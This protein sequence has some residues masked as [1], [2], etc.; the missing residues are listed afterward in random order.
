MTVRVL[1]LALA[2]VALTGELS[3]ISL[4]EGVVVGL[5]VAAVSRSADRRASWLL[6]RWPRALDLLGFFLWELVLSNLRVAAVVV[7]GERALDPAFVEVPLD[8]EDDGAIALFANLVTL[9][10]GTLSVDV[11]PHAGV[12]HVHTLSGSDP[13]AVCRELKQGF[14]R[15]IQELYR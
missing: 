8:L 12:L 13:D 1:L 2:W 5:L 9:T 4:A 6:R 15:R 14:E 3:V 7:R 10:P 11:P